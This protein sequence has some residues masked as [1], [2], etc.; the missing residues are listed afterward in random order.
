V[1]ATSSYLSGRDPQAHFGLG[2]LARIDSI[3][4]TPPAAGR[5]R[6]LDPP[7]DRRLQVRIETGRDRP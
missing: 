1:V 2:P 7:L 6:L 3:E 5:L 4:V